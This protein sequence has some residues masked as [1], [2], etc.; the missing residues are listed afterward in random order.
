MFWVYTNTPDYFVY[1]CLL[2][3]V[4]AAAIILRREYHLIRS[5][6]L[7]VKCP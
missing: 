6:Y 4:V 5:Q 1:T 7:A 3:C 2:F